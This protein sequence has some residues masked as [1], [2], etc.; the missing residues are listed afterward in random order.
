MRDVGG[1]EP[2]R[3]DI[4]ELYDAFQHS[5]AEPARAAAARPGGGPRLRRARSATRSST[6]STTRRCEG[7][8]L[9]ERRLRLRHDRPARAAA[10]RDDA[11]H[12]PAARRARR[13]RRAAAPAGPPRGPAPPRC[14]SPAARSPW[15]PPPSRGPWT[16]SG[17]RT[18]STWPPFGID[19]APVTNGEYAAFIDAG[20]YDDPRWWTAAGWA[21]RQ[22]A[23]LAA[24]A[25]LGARRRRLVAPP[26][27]RASSR[28]RCD[29]PVVHVCL[30]EAEAYA[31]LG[32]ASGCPPRPSGRRRRGTTPPPAARA[33]TRGATTTPTPAARQPRPAAPAPRAG[34]AP[35]PPA[36]RRSASTS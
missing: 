24:P 7:R 21:H 15:A 10:R 33:A 1:R 32:R 23:G 25:V 22:E 9:L 2:V 20:G 11:R 31:A 35:T 12:P 19:T 5:R 28:C 27:R 26:V 34:R 36:R 14:S 6:S 29:E 8:R 13:A 30:Y 16:T 18:R 4:D 3:Q 17:R